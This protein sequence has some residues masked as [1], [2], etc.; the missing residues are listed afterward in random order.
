MLGL[1]GVSVAYGA[2]EVLHDVTMEVKPNECVALVGS[3]GAGKSTIIKS[4]S[5][6]ISP[7]AGDILFEGQS[8]LKIPAYERPGLGIICVPEGRRVFPEMSVMDNLLIGAYSQNA[9][10]HAKE[11]LDAI[12]ILFPKLKER[13]NQAGN[14]LSGGEQQMLAIGRGLMG[15]P[16]LL[17]LDEPSLGLA[18]V[19]VDE[20]YANLAEI[21]KKGTSI[22]LIE[23]NI[24]RAFSISTRG[25]VLENGRVAFVGTKDEILNSERVKETYMGV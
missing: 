9:R 24:F 1:N 10:K 3:N 11:N 21:H 12:F 14:T 17:I 2:V 16:K 4:I 15:T 25:Y 6:L 18:P 19:I 5:G 23:E 7:L 8:I 22:L 20:V 13:I